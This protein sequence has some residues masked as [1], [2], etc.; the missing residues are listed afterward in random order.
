MHTQMQLLRILNSPGALVFTFALAR[1][2]LMACSG[3]ASASS[4]SPQLHYLLLVL[5]L[6]LLLHQSANKAIYI[7]ATLTY[8]FR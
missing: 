7:G 3:V 5:L 1:L 6:L 8:F 4:S 2:H